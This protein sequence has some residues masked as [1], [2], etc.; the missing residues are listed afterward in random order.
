MKKFIVVILSVV[1]SGAALA[2]LDASLLQY[3]EAIRPVS[4]AS[5]AAI[6][7]GEVVDKMPLTGVAVISLQLG[8]NTGATVNVALQAAPNATGTYANVSGAT[9][10]LT[11]TN[12]TI[13]TITYDTTKGNRYI[14]LQITNVAAGATAI[15]SGSVISYK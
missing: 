5:G 12:G 4:V 14:R 15:I 11:G 9:A 1:I 8:A 6:T 3:A 7:Y 13:Q 2:A 10:V